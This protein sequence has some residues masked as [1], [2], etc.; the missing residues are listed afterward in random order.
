MQSIPANAQMLR[1]IMGPDVDPATAEALLEDRALYDLWPGCPPEL[2]GVCL[3]IHV[4][5]SL[6]RGL[7]G[8][9]AWPLISLSAPTLAARVEELTHV[10]EEE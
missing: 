1:W 7:L 2:R 3:P 6:A 9:D 4:Q 5:V 8:G 10:R